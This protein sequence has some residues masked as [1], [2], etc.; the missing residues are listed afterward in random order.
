M[1]PRSV[2]KRKRTSDEELLLAPHQAETIRET[3]FTICIA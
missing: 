3:V 1:N 2:N